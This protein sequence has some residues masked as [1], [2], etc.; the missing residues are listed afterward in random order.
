[1][2]YLPFSLTEHSNRQFDNWEARFAFQVSTLN[3]CF[4]I[5]KFYDVDLATGR[6]IKRDI[7]RH[8]EG[9]ADA[10]NHERNRRQRLTA[11]QI[12][13]RVARHWSVTTSGC[14]FIWNPEVCM[15]PIEA[16]YQHP[17]TKQWVKPLIAPNSYR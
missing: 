17:Q 7:T 11:E 16:A 1:M 12:A 14:L 15:K 3:M 6:S 10:R 5:N 8:A 2:I 4:D 13:T 9:V